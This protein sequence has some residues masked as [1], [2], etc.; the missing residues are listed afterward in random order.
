MQMTDEPQ[1]DILPKL[2]PNARLLFRQ[3]ACY[4]WCAC[5]SPALIPRLLNP[6]IC[7]PAAA[8]GYN[9]LGTAHPE[10]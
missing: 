4:D 2:P 1:L 5:S 3:N 7:L 9:R 6:L 10:Y 8:Q